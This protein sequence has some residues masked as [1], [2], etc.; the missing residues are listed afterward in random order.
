MV[1]AA[2]EDRCTAPGITRRVA[3]AQNDIFC[4]ILYD[5]LRRVSDSRQGAPHQLFDMV[6][7][8]FSL[9]AWAQSLCVGGRIHL[10]DVFTTCKKERL[11]LVR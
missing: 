5:V 10:D 7:F 1:A 8:A 3:S 4:R 9:A 11:H 6:V 2:V